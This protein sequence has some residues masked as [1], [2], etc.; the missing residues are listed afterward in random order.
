MTDALDKQKV[1]ADLEESLEELELYSVS[2]PWVGPMK[3]MLEQLKQAYTSGYYD[4][5]EKTCTMV[6]KRPVPGQCMNGYCSECQG[7]IHE[8]MVLCPFCGARILEVGEMEV[9]T[10]DAWAALDGIYILDPDG[11]DRSDPKLRERLFTKQQYIN[12]ML[13][14]TCVDINDCASPYRKQ[15][16]E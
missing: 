16:E 1:L 14:S 13:R 10:L 8:N 2:E 5:P 7:E 15:A 12:G 3:R 4:L 6:E 11:F 9:R